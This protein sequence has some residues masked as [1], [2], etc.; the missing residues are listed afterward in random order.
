MF[1]H[2]FAGFKAVCFCHVADGHLLWQQIDL[3]QPGGWNTIYLR[4]GSD[5][6]RRWLTFFL[7][8]SCIRCYSAQFVAAVVWIVFPSSLQ[9]F[10]I[11]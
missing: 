5:L 9:S 2:T 10:R 6:E 8:H 11:I 7:R 3:D 4:Q 1:V